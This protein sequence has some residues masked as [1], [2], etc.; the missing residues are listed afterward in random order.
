MIVFMNNEYVKER[1]RRHLWFG[2][3]LSKI[4]LEA[5]KTAG[6]GVNRHLEQRQRDGMVSMP[7]G[8]NQLQ[9]PGSFE[10][11]KEI[12]RQYLQPSNE[13]YWM[14]PTLVNASLLWDSIAPM[15]GKA[16]KRPLAVFRLSGVMVIKGRR[17]EERRRGYWTTIKRR[18]RKKRII[19]LVR[20]WERIWN[21]RMRM[22]Y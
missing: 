16:V 11:T 13:K 20:D 3:H 8:R 5:K 17:E 21:T 19:S 18:E 1:K 15:N 7:N 6:L 2:E 4:F 10:N 14:H 12:E 22:R 9:I